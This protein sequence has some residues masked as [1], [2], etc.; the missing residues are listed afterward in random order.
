MKKLSVLSVFLIAMSAGVQAEINPINPSEANI[1]TRVGPAREDLEA[2][3]V[4]RHWRPGHRHEKNLDRQERAVQRQENAVEMEEERILNRQEQEALE[5]D[6]KSH[7]L[8]DEMN[9]YDY[10]VD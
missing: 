8:D 2:N 6:R 7:A 1:D 3:R 5:M 4:G 9:E 10:D